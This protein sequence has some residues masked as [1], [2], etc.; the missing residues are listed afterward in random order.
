MEILNGCSNCRESRILG[1]NLTLMRFPHDSTVAELVTSAKAIDQADIVVL[2]VDHTQF[3]SVDTDRLQSK[4][5][6][7]T[8]GFWS[9]RRIAR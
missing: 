2:L 1:P 9:S 7:D 5:V 8:R 4:V 6:F 3:A